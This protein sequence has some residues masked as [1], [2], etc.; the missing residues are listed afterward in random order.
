MGLIDIYGVPADW[1]LNQ[2]CVITVNTSFTFGF[3]GHYW[4]SNNEMLHLILCM[5]NETMRIAFS[6]A[7]IPDN[8]KS[9]DGASVI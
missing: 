6:G 1:A 4:V 7:E 8:P 2:S 3:K 9:V 5:L